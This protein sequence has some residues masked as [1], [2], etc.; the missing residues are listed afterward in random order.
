MEGV[1][2]N[3]L[4]NLFA[5]PPTAILLLSGFSF[6]CA[7]NLALLFCFAVFVIGFNWMDV[8]IYYILKVAEIPESFWYY[9]IP[10]GR[11]CSHLNSSFFYNSEM[12]V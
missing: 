12:R 6:K 11:L 5:F 3:C 7:R 2:V 4:V 8:M 10:L 1:S 9:F